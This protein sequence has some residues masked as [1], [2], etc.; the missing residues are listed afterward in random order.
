[1]AQINREIKVEF[2]KEKSVEIEKEN[3]EPYNRILT[4]LA[5]NLL[6][7]NEELQSRYSVINE[8][9]IISH[10]LGIFKIQET[11]V[12]YRALLCKK[13]VKGKTN[14]EMLKLLKN[15]VDNRRVETRWWRCWISIIQWIL[16]FPKH[17]ISSNVVSE[18]RAEEIV[19]WCRANSNSELLT[20][21]NYL[22]VYPI[23]E[24]GVIIV[25]MAFE[26]GFPDDPERKTDQ[27]VRLQNVWNRMIM[28]LTVVCMFDLVLV[29]NAMISGFLSLKNNRMVMNLDL[30][31]EFV[32]VI[33]KSTTLMNYARLYAMVGVGYFKD[34][35]AE[36]LNESRGRILSLANTDEGHELV[37]RWKSVVPNSEILATKLVQTAKEG[38][39]SPHLVARSWMELQ[40]IKIRLF[41]SIRNG[42][43]EINCVDNR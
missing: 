32:P 41:E 14:E 35:G 31:I 4:T 34:G 22:G 12:I 28:D 10:H 19:N 33:K 11:R 3:Y 16:F 21:N 24:E 6:K 42:N 7:V 2:E 36:M 37:E 18:T 5:Q 26:G 23:E 17:I 30:P 25:K 29:G 38:S 40:A 13:T 20:S 9:Q 43:I 27:I 8:V 39:F 15:L 1:M